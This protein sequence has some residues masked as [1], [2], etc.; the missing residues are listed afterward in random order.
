MRE[1]GATRDE[2]HA[3][4]SDLLAGWGISPPDGRADGGPRKGRHARKRI[5][6]QA[7][8]QPNPFNPST[9]I[10]YSLTEESSVAVAIF[11]LQGR[12]IRSYARGF[13]PVGTYSVTWDGTLS[14]G[15]FAPSGV[16]FYRITAGNEVTTQRML[17]MK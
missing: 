6:E 3:A 8:N 11:D 15:Q 14:T 16:Y 5:I 12:L 4:V 9:K 7:F 13:Q 2:I 10:G 17:L 1:S